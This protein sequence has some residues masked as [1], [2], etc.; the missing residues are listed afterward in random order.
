[1]TPVS[2]DEFEALR[3]EVSGLRRRVSELHP[4][5]EEHDD[6]LDE[7]DTAIGSHGLKLAELRQTLERLTAEHHRLADAITAQGG[8]IE[9]VVRN[10]ASIIALLGGKP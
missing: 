1:M 10:T 9:L 5:V 6:R 4:T 2:R 3:A 7:H 8:S